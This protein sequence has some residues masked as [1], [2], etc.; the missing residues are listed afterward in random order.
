[1][2]TE[3]TI[4]IV[5]DEADIRDVLQ[6]AFCDMGYRVI[7]A[8][9]GSEGL[10]LFAEHLP[11]VVLT[12]I[13]MPGMDGIQLLQKVKRINPDA[14][15]IM[16]TGHGDM[17]LA[18]KSLKYEATDFIT[19]PINVDVLEV[20]MK[21]ACDRILMRE[22][23]REYTES[24]ERLV[25]E[26]TE[27]QDRLASLGMMI[28][29]ISH[30]IKGMLTGLDGGLYLLSSGLQ[31]QR[32]ERVSEGTD[33]IGQMVERIR[34][35]VLDVLYYAKERTPDF[36]RVDAKAFAADVAL[37]IGP[38][39][40]N[41]S[42]KFISKVDPDA[43][44]LLMD[45]DAVLS[46][47]VNLLENAIDACLKDGKKD[48]H[49]TVFSIHDNGGHIAFAVEDDGIGMDDDTRK[50]LFTLFF[51]EKGKKGTGFGLF[52]ASTI[53]KQHGGWISVHSKL[54]KGSVF[55]VHL[56]KNPGKAGS[57]TSGQNLKAKA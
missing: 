28:G 27:L 4:L 44:D 19:K 32:M 33:I 53:V 25:R 30:G 11:P 56:P 50:N 9:N 47:L 5:D 54:G 46:A 6:I 40:E 34:K 20:A 21:R 26:K 57:K 29:S 16:I 38:R 36:E 37:V 15:V 2:K 17:E 1:M 23:L 14:E 48:E 13:K 41:T 52:V 39:F 7:T 45:S 43:G 42:V 8:E 22:K 3:P 18:V 24:L 55:T 31:N 35:M 49:T 12:D 10:A 51:S